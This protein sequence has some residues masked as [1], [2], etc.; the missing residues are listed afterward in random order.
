MIYSFG[1]IQST[2]YE[3]R[4]FHHSL[5]SQISLV[6][7][8]NRRSSLEYELSLFARRFPNDPRINNCHDLLNN[9]PVIERVKINLSAK[10]ATTYM[11][12]PF[13]PH[14][15]RKQLWTIALE[16]FR[17]VFPVSQYQDIVEAL[18]TKP[19][20][21]KKKNQYIA[22]FDSTHPL[23]YIIYGL[24]NENRKEE[25]RVSVFYY[26]IRALDTIEDSEAFIYHASMLFYD[27]IGNGNKTPSVDQHTSTVMA[28][29]RDIKEN[30]N[31]GAMPILADA[32]Q[33]A[34]Y[35]NEEV[36]KHL[37]AWHHFSRAS[38]ILKALG[39]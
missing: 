11:G 2:I 39:V 29:A 8:N 27:A 14:I 20:N 25:Q 6:N 21:K 3:R 9:L 17:F 35:T 26:L 19:L 38:W 12:I 24:Y 7:R 32:L 1:E 16:M 34:D 30:C 31:W 22:A 15:T 23:R 10:R 18:Y 33:D 37:R 28:I 5:H 36:L 13:Y 4:M